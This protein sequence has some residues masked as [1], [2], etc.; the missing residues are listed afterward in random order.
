M[1]IVALSLVQF[2]VW[3]KEQFDSCYPKLQI[4]LLFSLD[5]ELVCSSFTQNVFFKIA[6]GNS[7]HIYWGKAVTT[8]PHQ[9]AEQGQDTQTKTNQNNFSP[10]TCW[11]VAGKYDQNGLKESTPNSVRQSIWD[12]A[13]FTDNLAPTGS[14]Q[15]H[16]STKW[17]S[18]W[19]AGGNINMSS[20]CYRR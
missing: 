17:A 5:Q 6:L 11:V 19:A 7:M 2:R 18:L 3:L 15:S 13:A 4:W 12:H 9:T 16:Q 8:I 14:N 1:L 20:C 10:L